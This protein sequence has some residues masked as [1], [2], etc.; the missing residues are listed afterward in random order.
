MPP[1][2]RAAKPRRRPAP[3]RAG[4]RPADF[5]PIARLLG[6]RVR[7][8]R[9]AQELTV[10]QL[11]A[12]AG[13]SRRFLTDVELGKANVSLHGLARIAAALSLPLA[14]LVAPAAAAGSRL[15]EQLVALAQRLPDHALRDG[16]ARLEELASRRPEPRRIALIGLR[17]AGKSSLGRAVAAK[18]GLAFVELDHEVEAAAGMP[19][20]DLFTLHGEAYYRQLERHALQR[21]L[22]DGR[23]VIVATGG[24]I[25]AAPETYE[26]LRSRFTTI[27]LK[28][29]PE[30]HWNR[31]VAQGD[32]RPMKGQPAAKA[33]L[34]EI[35]AE[36]APLYRLAHE[37]VD[38]T[39]LGVA[40]SE[41]ALEELVRDSAPEGP[42]R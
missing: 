42:P 6:D 18:C 26:L 41:K 29:S 4:R 27:W 2:L 35:L 24:G 15:R 7:A 13:L 14:T 33:R 8:A 5:E 21:L 20:A 11:A 10:A 38:T 19:L 16:A 23:G 39:A 9:A 36:R 3:P 37:V 17:G 34:R 1:R 31:V 25:V 28:A 32:S 22:D 40:G 12:R 30:E